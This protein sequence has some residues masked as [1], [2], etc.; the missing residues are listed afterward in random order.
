MEIVSE[1]HGHGISIGKYSAYL[2]L[3]KYDDSVTVEDCHEM[4][5]SEIH[6]RI[7][8]HKHRGSHHNEEHD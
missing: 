4:S 3:A 7:S 6:R 1:A 2:Q 5:M 8:E